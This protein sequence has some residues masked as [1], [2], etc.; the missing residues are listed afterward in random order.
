M[1]DPLEMIQQ[2]GCYPKNSIIYV[3][4]VEYGLL[5]SVLMNAVLM[6]ET[7]ETDEKIMGRKVIKVAE[8]NYFRIHEDL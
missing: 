7:T 3:G 8:R 6:F 1:S 2:I 5:R 4:Y